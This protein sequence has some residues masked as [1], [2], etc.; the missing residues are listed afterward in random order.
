LPRCR[1]DDPAWSAAPAIALVANI[2]GAPS[3]L[4]TEARMLYDAQ[5]LYVAFRAADEE[6]WAA[7]KER[8]EHLWEEEV[9]E[10]FVQPN[11]AHSSYI[12]IEVNPL[13]TVL[14]IFLLDIRK[15]LPYRSWNSKRLRWAAQTAAK[16][17]TVEIALPFEDCVSAK[18]LPPQPGDRWR[19]N[20]YR[21]EH[22]PRRLGLAWSPTLKNDFHV[23]SRFGEI[24]FQ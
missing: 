14:D 13:G 17:W 3:P 9:V 7:M 19:V 8:D 24:V 4:A 23:P 11:P 12:E 2:D 22:K 1:L 16:E 20:L 5:Y 21:I 6:I 15:P 18:R 10:I